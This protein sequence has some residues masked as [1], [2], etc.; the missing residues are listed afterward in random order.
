MNLTTTAI[1]RPP[2]DF[3]CNGLLSVCSTTFV[4]ASSRAAKA[5]SDAAVGQGSRTAARSFVILWREHGLG[6]GEGNVLDV[7]KVFTDFEH[8]LNE[9]K[10]I[11]QD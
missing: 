8:T 7:A 6:A 4:R 10:T 5:A 1:H 3:G 11:S 2:N 9:Y